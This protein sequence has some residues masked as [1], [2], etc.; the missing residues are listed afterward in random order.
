M[1]VLVA[2]QAALPDHWGA[3]QWACVA[4]SDTRVPFAS[5]VMAGTNRLSVR[6]NFWCNQSPGTR[7]VGI[8][9]IVSYLDDGCTKC[10][11][12]LHSSF[13][14]RFYVVKNV[15]S[16]FTFVVANRSKNASLQS[17]L[18]RNAS[19]PVSDKTSFLFTI[20]FVPR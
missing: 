13:T 15:A 10:I 17:R 16:A 11:A 7:V 2:Q 4:S 1:V 12:T 8:P 18:C 14:W 20:V 9:F 3:D 5:W 6:R 19:F